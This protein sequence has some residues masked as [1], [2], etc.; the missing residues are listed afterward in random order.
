[1]FSTKFTQTPALMSAPFLCYREIVELLLSYEASTNI[2]DTKGSSPL[3]LAAWTGNLDIV[4]TLLCHGPSV[5]NVNLMV[6]FR[7]FL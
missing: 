3:H 4:R 6:R 5:P 1:M 7:L 2:V